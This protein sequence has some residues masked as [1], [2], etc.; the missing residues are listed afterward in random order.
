MDTA[1][2]SIL[3]IQS[4]LEAVCQLEECLAGECEIGATCRACDNHIEFANWVNC[5]ET[6]TKDKLMYR[7]T[8]KTTQS[9]AYEKQCRIVTKIKGWAST[10]FGQTC[11]YACL[12]R[13]TT[14]EVEETYYNTVNVS[15]TIPC[16][17]L[18]VP[19]SITQRCCTPHPCSEETIRSI[20]CIY[21]NIVCE[22]ARE[23]FY[24]ALNETEQALLFPYLRLA[25]AKANHSLAVTL[26]AAATAKKNL[27]EEELQLIEPTHASLTQAVETN[28]RYYKMVEA[29]ELSILKLKSLLSNL[30][31][32][33]LLQIEQI[34]FQTTLQ[35]PPDSSLIPV[36]ISAYL[37]KL[38]QPVVVTV[39]IDLTAPDELVKREVFNHLF[40]QM[41]EE[42]FRSSEKRKRNAGDELESISSVRRFQ[43]NCATI[44]NLKNYF[45]DIN[46]TLDHVL[47][48]SISSSHNITDNIKDIVESVYSPNFNSSRLNFTLIKEFDLESDLEE[49][50]KNT[51]AF[52]ELFERV[53]SILSV[54]E[55]VL[56]SS[57]ID[58]LIQW[59]IALGKVT[60][61]MGRPCFGLVDCFTISTLLVQELV[62]DHPKGESNTL[63]SL[64]PSARKNLVELALAT[65]VSL[66]ET[67]SKTGPMVNILNELAA[68]GYWCSDPPVITE[69][70]EKEQ[71][72]DLG[73]NMSISCQANSSL[74]LAYSWKRD[75]FLSPNHAAST[76]TKLTVNQTDEGTYQCL[77][78]NPVGTTS[79]LFSTITMFE[80]PVITLSPVD[81]TTFEGDDN[82]AVF[83][84]NAIATP[85]PKYQWYWSA[86]TDAWFGER[87]PSLFQL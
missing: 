69:H 58:A 86:N 10:I 18:P 3:D 70:P 11:S 16:S 71:F 80:P 43:A 83:V 76:F 55:T 78:T 57:Q 44:A 28:E 31:I 40:P 81:F 60:T 34:K 37:P 77:A 75:G 27:I 15:R 65:N 14:K 54:S 19:L 32:E 2:G 22:L 29:D 36:T 63:L 20:D 21:Q 33:S 59:R 45:Y 53:N 72:I 17:T 9:C 61:V 30:S 85:S 67:K 62:E 38:K 4:R 1:N 6:V 64:L 12:S 68:N 39:S 82:G 13:D 5:D 66:T 48:H 73:H 46:Q 50:A 41:M 35:G 47:F 52:V 7:V 26:L 56:Q 87:N 84:C 8:N 42:L 23:P 25:E 79:S 51:S 74:S 24:D 49:Q